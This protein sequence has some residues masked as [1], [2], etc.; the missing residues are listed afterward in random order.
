MSHRGPSPLHH[1]PSTLTLP[2]PHHSPPLHRASLSSLMQLRAGDLEVK[3]L[4]FAIQKTTSFEKMLAQRFSNSKYLETVRLTDIS[5]PP[6]PPFPRFVG[7]GMHLSLLQMMPSKPSAVQQSKDEEV[8]QR[9]TLRCCTC[10]RVLPC[11]PLI[12]L[13]ATLKLISQSKSNSETLMR[14][15]DSLAPRPRPAF[16]CLQYRK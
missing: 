12:H 13:S 1:S 8:R 3:L 11:Q 4:L 5:P 14:V 2:L 6:P 16:R 15:A 10:T 9:G 7:L